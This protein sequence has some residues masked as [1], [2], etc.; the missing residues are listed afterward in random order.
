MSLNPTA[1]FT[2][3][4]PSLVRRIWEYKF[5]GGEKSYSQEGE[6]RVLSR[7]FHGSKPGFFVDVGA[8]DP[9][10]F[11]NTHLF[12]QKGWRGVNV[13]AAPGSMTLF[14]K[15]RPGDTN[16]ES[17]VG[18]ERRTMPFFVFNEPALK[19][20]DEALSRSRES[21][22]Y[23]IVEVVQVPVRPLSE[24]LAGHLPGEKVPA[25]LTVDVEGLDLDVLRS[26]DW[27]VFRPEFVLVE[28]L[29]SCAEDV[30]GSPVTA[31][32]ASVGY[33]FEAK[34]MN[35]VFYRSRASVDV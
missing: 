3:L 13:D 35:T 18:L 4:F 6:D 15:H 24:I 5:S 19:S 1:L 28:C 8:H 12:Y 20:F 27:T 23:Q 31:F 16:V 17:G 32:M 7:Y 26:N 10:R 33:R 9:F 30:P 29:E 25:F 34:T 11:S 21:D 2:R 22:Q 14:R